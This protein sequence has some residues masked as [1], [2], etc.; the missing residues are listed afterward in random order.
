MEALEGLATTSSSWAELRR[1][2]RGGCIKNVALPRLG[3]LREEVE[4]EVGLKAERGM[5]F[6]RW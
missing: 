4:E 3:L 2:S 6:G 5:Q 1:A